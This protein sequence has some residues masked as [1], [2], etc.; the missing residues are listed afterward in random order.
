MKINC[1]AIDDEPLALDKIRE[2]IKRIGYLNLLDAFNNAIDAIDFM[3]N[4]RVD[5]I[6][7]D[8]QMEELTGIQM[9][10]SLTDK[11]KV[12]LTTAYDEYALKGYE[13]DV[14]D[15]LLKPI[16][17]Q[18]FLQACEKVYDQLFPLKQPDISIPDPNSE[19]ATKGYFF[20]KNGNIT[21][22]INFDDILFVEGMKDYLRIWTT[23]EK[24]MTLLS[25]KKLE[26]ALP[27]GD[28]MRIHKSYIVALDKIDSIDRSH[29]KI[30]NESLPV[31]NSYR[32][33][34]LERIGKD[35]IN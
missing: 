29:V 27:R 25:F 24:V 3:K 8:I 16:S 21:Q 7:L 17:F 1:I 30:G 5:L 32:R 18:R 26:E 13:L 15:Y 19:E 34:F 23:K 31:G 12:V 14:C 22:K 28:F 11:P 6:F 10:E 33:E 4:N 20:V 35:K 9:L 2:Y